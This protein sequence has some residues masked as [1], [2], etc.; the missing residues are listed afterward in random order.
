MTTTR[1]LMK[2]R[3]GNQMFLY[4]VARAIALEVNTQSVL[5]DKW[6][7]RK[8]IPNRLDCF[9]LSPDI[10]FEHQAHLNV[11]QMIVRKVANKIAY[12]GKLSERHNR[13]LK[14]KAF[15]EKNGL[16]LIT[17]G[18]SPLPNKSLLESRDFYLQ[19]YFQSE[20]Y[21]SKYKNEILHDF[22]FKASVVDK[23]RPMAK[24]IL[25]SSDSTCLHV[26]LGDYVKNPVYGVTTPSYYR[27][28]ISQLKKIK[29][30]AQIF[31]F[32]DEPAKAKEILELTDNVIC[33]PNDYDEQQSMYL[34]SLCKNFIIS[35][36]SFSW[37]M[38]YLSKSSDKLVFAP[39]KWYG[40]DIPCDLYCDDWKLIEV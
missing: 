24:E 40:R 1:I 9:C 33:I 18:Y 26:R 14:M 17:D 19:G 36:S 30:N 22:T 15:L 7:K 3:M 35:N 25:E 21:F 16:Y 8:K 13:Q 28:A 12:K 37:W 11:W 39:N 5:L 20:K 23:C 27:E 31:L 32:S 10:E 38:Q 29:P 34:G 4:A 2:G 6:L